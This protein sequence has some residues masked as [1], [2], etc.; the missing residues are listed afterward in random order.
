MVEGLADGLFWGQQPPT[1]AYNALRRL[2][3]LNNHILINRAV[4][5]PFFRHIENNV[6]REFADELGIGPQGLPRPRT[7]IEQIR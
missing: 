7:F 2:T 1:R 6:R 3:P 4:M 5:Q